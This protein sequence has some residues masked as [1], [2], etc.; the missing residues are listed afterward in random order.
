MCK[1]RCIS[2]TCITCIEHV[3]THTSATHV[4]HMYF[5]T[6]TTPKT[7]HMYNGVAQLYENVNA[8]KQADI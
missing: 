6:Y 5:Y 7:P 1:Y 3:I 4:I 8:V 2:Y